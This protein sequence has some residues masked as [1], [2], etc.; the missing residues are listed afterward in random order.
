LQSIANNL[1]EALTDYKGVT[2]SHNSVVNV[3]ERVEIPTQNLPNQNKR[4]RSM[5]TKD[6]TPKQ[7]SRKQRK[8]TSKMV[9]ANQH[10]V[11]RH[12]LDVQNPN[13]MHVQ[14]IH[15]IFS[16]NVHT[17]ISARTSQNLDFCTLRNIEES[18]RV[19]EISANYIDLEESFN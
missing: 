2:K 16:T 12:Q 19:N 9:N 10:Y 13:N 5:V 8:D 4:G 11:G 7:H 6:K 1:I 15:H 14:L 3:P 18:Q 17:N